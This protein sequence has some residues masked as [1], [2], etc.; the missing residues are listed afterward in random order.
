MLYFSPQFLLSRR[1]CCIF[2]YCSSFGSRGEVFAHGGEFPLAFLVVVG[3]G[4]G[5]ETIL[6]TRHCGHCV[7][8]K[9]Q[10]GCSFGLFN[11]DSYVSFRASGVIW[12]TW[13]GCRAG[14][15]AHL[16]SLPCPYTVGDQ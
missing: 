4:H 7:F 3:Y 1:Y 2:Y 11:Y 9:D 8:V 13:D 6:L 15:F 14:V 10:G 5:V 16:V 12:G